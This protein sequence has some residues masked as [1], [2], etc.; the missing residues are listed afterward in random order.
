M[1]GV[2]SLW[3][4]VWY[5]CVHCVCGMCHVMCV[6]HI[7]V[8]KCYVWCMWYVAWCLCV[9]CMWCSIC[10]VRYVCLWYMCGIWCVWC[11]MCMHV[12]YVWCVVSVL[13]VCMVCVWYVVCVWNVVWCVCSMVCVWLVCGMVCMCVVRM[14]MG[15]VYVCVSGV[16]CLSC[17][18][19]VCCMC[20]ECVVC[21]WYLCGVNMVWRMCVVCA[22]FGVC[23]GGVYCMCIECVVC[24]W[25]CVCGVSTVWR[26]CVWCVYVYRVCVVLCM[27][28]EHGIES[29][30][31]VLYVYGWCSVYVVSS[32]WC[33]HGMVWYVLVVTVCVCMCVCG[34]CACRT[35][36]HTGFPSSSVPQ[37]RGCSHTSQ[38][39]GVWALSVWCVGKLRAGA[40]SW[41]VGSSPQIS[42]RSRGDCWGGRGGQQ[43]ENLEQPREDAEIESFS[44]YTSLL[45][46]PR[47]ARNAQAQ[48]PYV[49]LCCLIILWLQ[50]GNIALGTCSR[51]NVTPRV[52]GW[53]SCSLCLSLASWLPALFGLLSHLPTRGPTGYF[54][55]LSLQGQVMVCACFRGM[56]CFQRPETSQYKVR[57]N[58]LPG[59]TSE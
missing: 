47:K 34:A 23:V 10:G 13:C 22:W 24:A 30:C 42:L 40:G 3:Y 4:V 56:I 2:W 15:C 49:S 44:T 54:V 19:C 1:C 7:C 57:P 31:G 9:V 52:Q 12:M 55:F 58:N 20:I 18:V 38:T 35:C 16:W 36:T 39:L 50:E 41:A 37:A 27:W 43:R 6:C 25:Y 8:F 5:L 48:A 26:V 53:V 33:E 46:P 11:A 29:A 45:L 32:V 28:C 17:V 14:C 59:I 21:A 51:R